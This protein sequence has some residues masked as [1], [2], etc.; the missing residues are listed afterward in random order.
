[1]GWGKGA[2]LVENLCCELKRPVDAIVRNDAGSYA[3]REILINEI[4]KH[5]RL[6]GKKVVIWEFTDRELVY[7]NWKLLRLPTAVMALSTP[8][9]SIASSQ[10]APKVIATDS[11][12]T[13]SAP[14]IFFVPEENKSYTITA[15]VLKV[16]V[17]PVPGVAPY[18]DHVMSLLIGSIKGA[19]QDRTGLKALVYLLSMKDQMLTP[20]AAIRPGQTIK[21]RLKNWNNVETQYGGFNRSELEDAQL[22]LQDPCW[23]ELE[24]ET[25]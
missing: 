4:S 20:A 21:L 15:K 1:M 3:T 23:G 2:G 25:K 8:T 16:S 19:G 22:M 12:V 7:G 17:V 11:A 14:E 5:N 10:V 6:A 13:K 9:V 24:N 18:K